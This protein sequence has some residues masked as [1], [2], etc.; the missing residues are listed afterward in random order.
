MYRRRFLVPNAVTLGNLFCGFL[1][2]IYSCS[3]RFE[4]AILAIAIALLLDGLDGRL[5]RRLH[6]TS[7][8]GVEFDS[9]SDLVSFGLAPALLIYQ[10]AFRHGAD[11]FGVIM[12]FGYTLC[13]AGRLARFNVAQSDN[14]QGFTGLPTPAAAAMVVS[15]VNLMPNLGPPKLLTAVAAALMGSLA[16]L[17]VSKIEYVSVKKIKLKGGEI[18]IVL[19]ALIALLW[20][21]NQSGLFV[22]SLGYALSGPIM[23]LF[24]PKKTLDSAPKIDL[25]Q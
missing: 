14:I 4:K 20:Y 23:L 21:F 18:F 1:S 15:F 24:G 9:F 2:I 12:T 13:A 19:G 8:F 6:A 22:I 10:W 25:A 16:F 3:D 5:A 17:M 11:E 7:R